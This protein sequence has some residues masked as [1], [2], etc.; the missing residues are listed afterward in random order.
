MGY[1]SKTRLLMTFRT[2][3]GGARRRITLLATSVIGG[4][5]QTDPSFLD[6]KLNPMTWRGES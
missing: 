1:P 5:L 3:C 2:S 4:T 6:L